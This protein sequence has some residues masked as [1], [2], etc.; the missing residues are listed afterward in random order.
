[1][2]DDCWKLLDLEKTADE[3]KIRRAYARKLKEFR[4]D[5][6]PAGFQRL[7]EAR[8]RALFI[9]QIEDE[10]AYSEAEAADA[11]PV[12]SEV[13]ATPDTED[14]KPAENPFAQEEQ[15]NLR[16]LYSQLDAM[17]TDAQGRDNITCKLWKAANWSAL[18]DQ[19]TSLGFNE[20]RAFH[21]T[22]ARRLHEFLPE[23]SQYRAVDLVGFEAG[24]GPAAIVE[25]IEAECEFS[26]FGTRFAQLSY[27]EAADNYLAWLAFAQ[28]ARQV[29]D[30]RNNAKTAYKRADNQMPLFTAD[31]KEALFEDDELLQYFNKAEATGRWPFK[32]KYSGLVAPAAQLLS[33]NYKKSALAVAGISAAICVVLYNYNVRWFVPAIAALIV[34]ALMRVYCAATYHRRAVEQ[35]IHY[36]AQA[37]RLGIMPSTERRNFLKFSRRPTVLASYLSIFEFVTVVAMTLPLILVSQSWF[38]RDVLEKTAETV[39]SEQMLALLDVTADNHAI[40]TSDF[41]GLFDQIYAP[42]SYIATEPNGQ[43][44]K[45]SDLRT[46]LGTAKIPQ[47]INALS[48]RELTATVPLT[49]LIERGRKL[50]KIADLYR[51]SSMSERRKIE[52]SLT[53]WTTFIWPAVSEPRFEAVLWQLMPPKEADAPV[54]ISAAHEIRKLLLR[55]A[56]ERQLREITRFDRPAISKGALQIQMLLDLSDDR[57]IASVD[58]KASYKRTQENIQ[59]QAGKGWGKPYPD[60]IAFAFMVFQ[61]PIAP[62]FSNSTGML[63]KEDSPATSMPLFD[64]ALPVWS[65]E[66]MGWSKFLYASSICLNAIETADRELVQSQMRNIIRGA[67]TVS[68]DNKSVFWKNGA[69]QLLA[70]PACSMRSGAF[71]NA[72]I[73]DDETFDSGTSLWP[74]MYALVKKEDFTALRQ[75]AKFGSAMADANLAVYGKVGFEANSYLAFDALTAGHLYQALEYYDKLNNQYGHCQRMHALNGSLLSAAGEKQQALREFMRK[76]I[77][78]G[79]ET[80]VFAIPFDAEVIDDTLKQ[81]EIDLKLR[82]P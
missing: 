52:Q 23:P 43:E 39:L 47:K 67:Q 66:V 21:E 38:Y 71:I 51:A 55:V 44:L 7:V 75:A 65:D 79:C 19:A 68:P 54:I 81:L 70:I 80:L 41:I 33:A 34:F 42:L 32:L 36:V 28:S 63:M 48:S 11:L 2:F 56:I 30:R 50:R 18:F 4:P 20:H 40:P 3:R 16:Q 76:D 17:I 73:S 37:D 62:E 35:N 49:P 74:E 61:N 46:S 1:M 24:Y 53:E 57:L 5:E 72:N 59:F 9:A 26:W 31:D 22:I 45:V 15:E 6:D 77:N 69:D 60:D 82:A 29:I 14:H 64:E 27:S 8:D 25:Q 78:S 13:E 10:N 12:V 58:A